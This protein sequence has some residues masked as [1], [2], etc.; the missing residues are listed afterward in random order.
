MV[1][2]YLKIVLPLS[3]PPIAYAV[4][5][6]ENQLQGSILVAAIFG[7][8]TLRR[9]STTTTEPA[10]AI[11]EDK[12]KVRRLNGGPSRKLKSYKE[13]WWA[14]LFTLMFR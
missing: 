3:L 8:D 4:L 12:R 6:T 14:M 9:L 7:L 1:P 11:G 5:N 2:D 13:V 10:R